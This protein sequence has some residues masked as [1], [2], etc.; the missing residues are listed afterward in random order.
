VYAGDR[1]ASVPR[2]RVAVLVDQGK[3]A[4]IA[5]DGSWT[6]IPSLPPEELRSE[7]LS[8]ASAGV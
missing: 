5:H 1:G 4:Q 8:S 7:V 3:R 2:S 6:E